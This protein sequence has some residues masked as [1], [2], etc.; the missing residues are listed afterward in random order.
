MDFR[1][2]LSIQRPYLGPVVG[3]IFFYCPLAWIATVPSPMTALPP[4]TKPPLAMSPSATD[5]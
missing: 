1:R 3:T 5:R 4:L 2:C